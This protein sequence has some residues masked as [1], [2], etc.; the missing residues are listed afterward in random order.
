MSLTKVK[1]YSRDSKPFG[2]TFNEWSAKWWQWLLVIPKSINPAMDDTG[3]HA[4]IGQIDPNVFF[5]CQ[6]IEGVKRLPMRTISIPRGRS[7]F[8]P[9]LNW[10]SNFYEH[11]NSEQELIQTAKKRMDVIGHIEVK[12]DGMAIQGLERY[13]SL[14]NFFVVKLPEDNVLDLPAGRARLVS[15]GYW[16]FTK[17]IFDDVVISTD[18]SCSSGT[19]RIAVNYSIKVI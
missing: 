12:C 9:I 19:T 8:M 16:I 7:I 4:H 5:L 6:T 17:P 11:G 14:S 13:R 2:L 10:I 18:G 3:H 1:I 15:D